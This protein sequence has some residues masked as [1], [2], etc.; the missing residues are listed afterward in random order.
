MQQAIPVNHVLIETLN[1]INGFVQLP[2]HL[3]GHH[4][5]LYLGAWFESSGTGAQFILLF[6]MGNYLSFVQMSPVTIG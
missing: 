4:V 5:I 3:Q 1:I 6:L 2:E